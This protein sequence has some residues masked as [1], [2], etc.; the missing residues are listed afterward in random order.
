M[1]DSNRDSP[2]TNDGSTT[3]TATTWSEE[4]GRQ[5]VY[6]YTV[7]PQT[8]QGL[9]PSAVLLVEHNAT[10]TTV[11]PVDCNPAILGIVAEPMWPRSSHDG[12]GNA[13]PFRLARTHRAVPDRP[14]V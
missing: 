12:G 3:S 13:R 4:R 8:L 14:G 10:Q 9:P 11:T 7:E 1:T 5:R 2:A 6:E